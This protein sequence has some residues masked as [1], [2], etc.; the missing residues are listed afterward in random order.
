MFRFLATDRR[1][2]FP[3]GSQYFIG[4]H[5]E[6]LPVATMRRQQRKVSTSLTRI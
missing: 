1:F 4:T 3:N 2:H 5:N 6:T